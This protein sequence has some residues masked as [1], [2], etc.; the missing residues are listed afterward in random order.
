MRII[1]LFFLSFS[2]Y[3]DAF[4]LRPDLKHESIAYALFVYE[5][6]NRS[7]TIQTVKNKEFKK[8][9]TKTTNLG[10]SRSR[11]WIRFDIYNPSDKTLQWH[12]NFFHQQYDFMESWYFL[13]NR[14][15]KHEVKGDH[16]ID[17]D[18]TSYYERTLF[19]FK[20]LPMRKQASIFH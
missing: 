14:L 17:P 3:A 4:T 19:T 2:L 10:I 11:Y 18:T 8:T 5:D 15:I 6:V 13:E 20:L 16:V 12:L 7:E 1:I 9:L